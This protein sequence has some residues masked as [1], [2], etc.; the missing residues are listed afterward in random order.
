MNV[1][2]CQLRLQCNAVIE[3]MQICIALIWWLSGTLSH[4]N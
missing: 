1:N 4:T 2:V 3:V